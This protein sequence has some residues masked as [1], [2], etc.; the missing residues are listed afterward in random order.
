[1][2]NLGLDPF[3]IKIL[4]VQEVKLEQSLES[5]NEYQFHISDIDGCIV[6][7]QESV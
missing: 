1:M 4:L 5:E 7:R 2:Y 6:L 3:T